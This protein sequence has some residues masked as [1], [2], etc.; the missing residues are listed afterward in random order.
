[1]GKA[2]KG[3]YELMLEVRDNGGGEEA[4]TVTDLVIR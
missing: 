2:K 1:M 4:S 3:K